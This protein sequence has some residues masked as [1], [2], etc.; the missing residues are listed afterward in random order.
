M[1]DMFIKNCLPYI[2]DLIL[3]S[4]MLEFACKMEADILEVILC[5]LKHI[6]RVS[7][8]YIAT[9]AVLCH[10]LILTLLEIFKF[11]RVVTFNP[12]CLV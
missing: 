6:A 10:V 11:N 1:G 5:H 2:Y 3:I 7:K 12:T 9:F 4:L 8:E